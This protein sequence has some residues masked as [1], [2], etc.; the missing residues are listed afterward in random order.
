MCNPFSVR[1]L[2]PSRSPGREGSD[3]GEDDNDEMHIEGSTSNNGSEKVGYGWKAL[4]VRMDVF[5]LRRVGRFV[6]RWTGVY[7]LLRSVV[8]LGDASTTSQQRMPLS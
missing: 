8:V 4:V 2:S 5:K 1:I 3:G 6:T 7:V